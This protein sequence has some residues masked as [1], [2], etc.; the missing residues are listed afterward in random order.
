[1]EFIKELTGE[2]KEMMLV[3]GRN[4]Y[5]GLRIYSGNLMAEAVENASVA[6][7]KAAAKRLNLEI[8]E[9]SA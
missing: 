8:L 4:E 6:M 5:K 2:K 3:N 7:C 9:N 1:M